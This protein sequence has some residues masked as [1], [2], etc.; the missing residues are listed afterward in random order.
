MRHIGMR[1]SHSIMMITAI[2]FGMSS[3]EQK[4]SLILA[5]PYTPLEAQEHACVSVAFLSK[6][7]SLFWNENTTY[8]PKTL[9]IGP[10]VAGAIAIASAIRKPRLGS[11]CAGAS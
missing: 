11:H 3:E 7:T 1:F 10:I 2:I 4:F 8:S 6:T 5:T 9:A